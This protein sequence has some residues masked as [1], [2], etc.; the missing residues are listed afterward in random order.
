MKDSLTYWRNRFR[1]HLWHFRARKGLFQG[2]YILSYHSISS[3]PSDPLGLR[4]S[5][6]HFA[7]Q[8]EVIRSYFEPVPLSEIVRRLRLQKPLHNLM[9][10]TFDDGYADNL[11]TAWP[12][13]EKY[14]VPATVF[15]ITGAVEGSLPF[16]WEVLA[17]ALLSPVRPPSFP[18]HLHIN[19]L[20]Y[21][22]RTYR[23]R[24][25]AYQALRQKLTSL[26]G[27]RRLALLRKITESLGWEGSPDPAVRSL[28]LSELQ[29]LA[30]S[31]LIE[32]GSH[33]VSHPQLDRLPFERVRWELEASRRE[34]LEWIGGEVRYFAYPYGRENG[35][36]RRAVQAVG[37]EAAFGT[38]AGGVVERS[39]LFSLPRLYVGDWSGERFARYL[40][41]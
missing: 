27:E 12:L 29:K 38:K 6:H 4:V 18:T 3:H 26:Y 13:L 39:D 24:L 30:S 9:A 32:I 41:K 1:Y 16:Y 40:G 21:S 19:T 28:T 7:Q 2:A 31:P 37:Y 8:L 25:K 23:E 33:T 15:V 35:Q 20:R 17:Q 5:P 14:Q 10:L 22:L 34:L 36:L 11:W